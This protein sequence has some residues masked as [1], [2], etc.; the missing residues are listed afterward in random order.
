MVFR[1]RDRLAAAAAA[2]EILR[3]GNEEIADRL[4]REACILA[5]LPHSPI[6]RT[7]ASSPT[8]GCFALLICGRTFA[9]R[10]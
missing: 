6:W 9:R 1:S 10:H 5:D 7:R 3:P 2:V 8:S 4:V